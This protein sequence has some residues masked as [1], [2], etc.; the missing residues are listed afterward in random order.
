MSSMEM[1]GVTAGQVMDERS[2]LR[3]TQD[4]NVLAATHFVPRC[5]HWHSCLIPTVSLVGACFGVDHPT[6]L[7]RIAST[8]N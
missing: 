1:A 4:G 5:S 6:P 2:L 3:G 7:I 8:E